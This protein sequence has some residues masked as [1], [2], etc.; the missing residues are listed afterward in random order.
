MCKCI[1]GDIDIETVLSARTTQHQPFRRGLRTKYVLGGVNLD[2]VPDQEKV[3]S[4]IAVL[5]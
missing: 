3:Y 5:M 1:H 2:T 4:R